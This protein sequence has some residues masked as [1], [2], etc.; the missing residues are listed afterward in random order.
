MRFKSRSLRWTSSKTLTALSG[1][2]PNL[3]PHNHTRL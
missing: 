1:D 2:M 3:S